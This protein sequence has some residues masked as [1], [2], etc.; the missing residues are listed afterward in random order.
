MLSGKKTYNAI[1][2]VFFILSAAAA[3]LQV[4][5]CAITYF[6]VSDG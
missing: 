6:Q 1:A 3:A 4:I 5:V 2:R